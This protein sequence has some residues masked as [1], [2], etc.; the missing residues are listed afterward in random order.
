MKMSRCLAAAAVAALVIGCGESGP[1]VVSVTGTVTLN[2]KPLEGASVSF[3]PELSTNKEGR[4][5]EDITGP[6]GNYKAMTRGRSG[7]VPGKYHVVVTKSLVDPAKTPD[8]FKDDPYMASMSPGGPGKAK[9]DAPDKIGGE[10][11]REV[12]PEGGV[13]D[14]DVKSSAPDKP[15]A[16]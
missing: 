5:G 8:A 7:L 14:F 16:K 11:D 13:Q 12:P 9:K 3:F 10:F 1:K 2:G 15:A 6:S 4:A